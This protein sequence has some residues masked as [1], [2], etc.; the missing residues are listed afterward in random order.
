MFGIGGPELAVILVVAL[1]FVGPEKL[2]KVART[3]G[4]GL[5]DLRRAAN[6]AQAELKETVDDLIREADLEDEAWQREQA[7]KS[8]EKPQPEAT[9]AAAPTAPEPNATAAVPASAES[10]VVDSTAGGTAS[11]ES[12]PPQDF[13]QLL[14]NEANAWES[15]S[16]LPF[17]MDLPGVRLDDTP[18][19]QV[20]TPKSPTP[21]MPIPAV[22]VANAEPDV[23]QGVSGTQARR[24]SPRR[25]GS[26]AETEDAQT[27]ASDAEGGAEGS[28]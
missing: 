10:L 9:A 19:P 3:V 11:T 1:I 7:A 17:E 5:R 15:E 18:S 26:P 27:H 2:P 8:S 4:A 16:E 28:A 20:A 24:S 25:S 12:P 6:L 21:S 23:P 14:A 13:A 22:Q